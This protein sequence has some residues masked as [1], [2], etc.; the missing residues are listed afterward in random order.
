M[1]YLDFIPNQK[2]SALCLGTVLF[3]T[4]IPEKD[5]FAQ[6]DHFF[7]HGGNFFDT[8]R[9][10][11]EWLPGGHGSSET[12]LGRWIKQRKCRD[13]AVISTKGAHPDLKT[14]NV[15]RMS[16]SELRSDLEES[17][18]ALDTDYIDIYF[19]HRDDVSRPIEEILSSLEGFRKE[20]KI[21]NYGFSN[22]TLTRMLEAGAAANRNGFPGF[23]CNQIRFGL[24]DLNIGEISDKTLVVMDQEI[25][26]W[27]EK[28][29]KPLMAYTSS[30][31][32]Y[33]SKILNGK[34]LPH[35]E[36][37]YSNPANGKILEKLSQWE[38]DLNVPA[39]ALVS[40]Y[41]MNQNF[42]SVPI[43]AFSSIEQMEEVIRAADINLPAEFMEQIR[44]I[45]RFIC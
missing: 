8:A 37:I 14:M 33:F 19:L 40:A 42:P 29:K 34:P 18:R 30:C 17:L 1:K 11:A 9:I 28:T 35:Q 24:A 44:A 39:A 36:K 7:E 4:G 41:V 21:K 20:G 25:L 27:H 13:R 23:I 22:W 10:Y 15:P 45:K 5:A 16:K 3:G 31:N 38:K 26:E 12:C 32:G 43:S 6:M 2:I